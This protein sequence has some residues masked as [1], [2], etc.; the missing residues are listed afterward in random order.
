MDRLS[1]SQDT[2]WSRQEKTEQVSLLQGEVG[3]HQ[4]ILWGQ[5]MPTCAQRSCREQHGYKLLQQQPLTPSAT[6]PAAVC[7]WAHTGSGKKD[8]HWAPLNQCSVWAVC[9][10]GGSESE[11]RNSISI[12]SKHGCFQLQQLLI[13]LVASTQAAAVTYLSLQWVRKG[14]YEKSRAAI[15]LDWKGLENKA[16]CIW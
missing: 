1:C 9:L 13:Q 14:L 4:V 6:V 12:S 7:P 10:S 15:F 16:L 11:K 2:Q 8:M 3:G 5:G